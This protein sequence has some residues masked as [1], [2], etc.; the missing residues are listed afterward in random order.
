MQRDYVSWHS[1]RLGRTM[2]LLVFGHAGTPVVAFPSSRG[3]F[4]EWE[5]FGMVAALAGKLDA[6]HNMLFCADSV[7]EESLYNRGV[8]PRVRIVR[9]RQYERYVMDELLPFAQHRARREFVIATGASFGAYHAVNFVFKQ[10]WRFGK[11]IS[12]SGAFD[13]RTQLD[14]HYDDDVYFSNPI[15]YLPNLRDEGT[16]DALRRTPI[17]LTAGEHD[18]CRGANDHLSRVL[19]EKSIGHHYERADGFGHDWPWWR[20]QIRRHVS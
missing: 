19:H 6:G 8:H 3:R 20:D 12:L 13:I 17:V 14:G 16:L 7:D 9:H 10:P 15:D 18:P 5:D 11:L 2:E 1:P 4:H